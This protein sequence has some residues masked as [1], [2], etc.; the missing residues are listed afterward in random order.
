MQSTTLRKR[1]LRVS[2]S[3]Y[4][5]QYWNSCLIGS[6]ATLQLIMSLVIA[7]VEIGN[8]LVDLYKANVYSGF[9]SFPFM[10]AAAIATYASGK[11]RMVE[12]SNHLS[13]SS[14]YEENSNESVGRFGLSVCGYPSAAGRHWISHGFR[15]HQFHLVPRLSMLSNIDDIRVR[16]QSIGIHLLHCNLQPPEA[17]VH[18]LW[19]GVCGGFYSTIDHLHRS[20]C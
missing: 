16:R 20:V 4:W 15:C 2:P 18:C 7:G 6:I 11:R 9:W 14:L 19:T 17:C 3:R 8:A 1:I 12:L 5:S 13:S 10:L